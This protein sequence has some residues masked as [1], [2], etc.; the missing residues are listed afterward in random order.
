MDINP[1]QIDIDTS[2]VV[3][4]GDQP[5]ATPVAPSIEA[6]PQG[7]DDII[8]K[9]I[10]GSAF[11]DAPKSTD[12]D[13]RGRFKPKAAAPAEQGTEPEAQVEPATPDATKDA[14]AP[15][16]GHFRGWS[17][18]ERA[19][20]EKLAPEAKGFVLER[21]KAMQSHMTKVSDE[22]KLLREFTEPLLNT[23]KAND[24]YLTRVTKDLGLNAHD[25]IGNLMETENTLRFG[26]YKDK[27]ALFRQMAADYR[28]PVS[29]GEQDQGQQLPASQ[30][31]TH[32]VVHDLQQEVAQLKARL[33]KSETKLKSDNDA[34]FKAEV[35]AFKTATDANGN[36]LHPYFD[37][38][39]GVMDSVWRSGQAKTLKEAYDMATAPIEEAKKDAMRKLQ[40]EQQ[41]AAEK[42]RRA[43]PV[44]VSGMAPGGSTKA[45]SLDEILNGALDAAGF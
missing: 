41:A 1:G 13:E 24:E 32:P 29:F 2:S 33:E 10:D 3:P 6:E 22:A 28:I 45:T 37:R 16:E 44:R 36:P 14:P 38:V 4:A 30:T 23:F 9:A 17:K 43:A 12:R 5:L 11:D 35:E 31:S 27:V 40:A 39:V 7:I 8:S 42:A 19:A 20:F 18:E 15:S 21:Q 26:T 34:R 25:L